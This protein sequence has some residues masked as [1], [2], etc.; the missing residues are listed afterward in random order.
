MLLGKHRNAGRE[1]RVG[2][3]DRYGLER[4]RSKAARTRFGAA[5]TGMGSGSELVP[6][7]LRVLSWPSKMRAGKGS[8]CQ[9]G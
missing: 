9:A 6:G 3:P 4:R 7:A 2:R 5:R 8:F 1:W